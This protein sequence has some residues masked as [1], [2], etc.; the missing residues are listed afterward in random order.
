MREHL[1]NWS[2]LIMSRLL[3]HS[4]YKTVRTAVS[5]LLFIKNYLKSSSRMS[6]QIESFTFVTYDLN[7]A[8]S[9]YV[10]PAVP[11]LHAFV[12]VA[13][14]YISLV[15]NQWWVPLQSWTLLHSNIK[16][17]NSGLKQLLLYIAVYLCGITII[18]AQ[19]CLRWK[20]PSN[21]MYQNFFWWNSFYAFLYINKI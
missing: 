13:M 12:Q 11:H 8:F 20:G 3:H 6:D 5:H 18:K 21:V 14:T 16:G 4:W 17:F 7:C 1:C 2:L 15:E 9:S 10:R 19:A